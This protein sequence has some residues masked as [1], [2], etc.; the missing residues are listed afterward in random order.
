MENGVKFS[1]CISCAKKLGVVEKLQELGDR[2][3]SM[4]GEPLTKI[5]KWKTASYS[6]CNRF[7]E[8]PDLKIQAI[9]N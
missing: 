6:L 1:A 7:T 9:Q 4:A 5:L 2:G 8:R 3:Y